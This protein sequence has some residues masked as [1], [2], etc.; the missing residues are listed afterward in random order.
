MKTETTYAEAIKSASYSEVNR[1]VAIKNGD[2]E[3]AER[4]GSETLGMAKIISTIYGTWDDDD[5]SKAYNDIMDAAD[6]YFGA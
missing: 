2:Y 1:R 6:E 5:F 3:K 4:L